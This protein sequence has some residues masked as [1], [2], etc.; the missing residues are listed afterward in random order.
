MTA[1]AYP[2]TLWQAGV[3]TIGQQNMIVASHDQSTPAFYIH[4]FSSLLPGKIIL[5]PLAQLLERQPQ[6]VCKVLWSPQPSS[7]LHVS[8]LIL[9]YLA[10]AAS[11]MLCRAVPC[12]AMPCRAVPCRAM[13]CRAV[14]CRAV[15]FLPRQLYHGCHW[16]RHLCQVMRGVSG[17][18]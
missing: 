8:S 9:C 17:D 5:L 12:R 10:V 1:R 4:T 13:P 2:Y 7:S 3:R 15:P 11:S 16:K 14:L 6:Q 18:T